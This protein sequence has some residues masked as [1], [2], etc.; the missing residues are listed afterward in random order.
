[1]NSYF[2][3]LATSFDTRTKKRLHVLVSTICHFAEEPPVPAQDGE[4]HAFTVQ[5]TVIYPDGTVVWGDEL[6]TG[7]INYTTRFL[8]QDEGIT[9]EN[10]TAFPVTI[11]IE[12]ARLVLERDWWAPRHVKNIER[13]LTAKQTLLAQALGVDPDKVLP[14][15]EG[16]KLIFHWLTDTTSDELRACLPQLLGAVHAHATTSR[17][18]QAT[19]K[20]TGNQRYI[21]R[22][23]LLRLGFNGREHHALRVAMGRN[24]T[25]SA[26]YRT[27]ESEVA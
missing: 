25:G 18:L 11:T 9:G 13:I 21:M 27:T 17:K 8:D 2:R 15:R 4:A 12:D 10:I 26:A 19:S 1:M 23:W 24:L 5:G 6:D 14:T 3:P 20:A 7:L 16:N 22:C